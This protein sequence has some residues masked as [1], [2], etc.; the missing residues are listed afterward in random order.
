MNLLS[1]AESSCRIWQ[2]VVPSLPV[3]VAPLFSWLQRV[4]K[5]NVYWL[6]SSRLATTHD[7]APTSKPCHSVSSVNLMPTALSEA[8]TSWMA[9]SE[10]MRRACYVLGTYRLSSPCGMGERGTL[11]WGRCWQLCELKQGGDKQ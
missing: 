3:W 4:N 1:F 5:P 2:K 8:L 11:G 9:N 7:L 10:G 6:P